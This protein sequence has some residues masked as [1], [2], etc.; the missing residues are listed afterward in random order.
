MS[1]RPNSVALLVWVG[2][3]N[4]VLAWL[5]LPTLHIGM[6]SMTM[7]DARSLMR[8]LDDAGVIVV[9]SEAAAGLLPFESGYQPDA[10][11]VARA[12]V[13]PLEGHSLRTAMI[14]VLIL[15]AESVVLLG[16][17]LATRSRRAAGLSA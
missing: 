15:T 12:L 8:E 10:D 16:I 7:N 1:S 3:I 5:V 2:V 13:F 9:D 6:Y 11:A 14:T 17:G 4:L